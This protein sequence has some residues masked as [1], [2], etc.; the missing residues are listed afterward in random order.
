M[1]TRHRS[2]E[3]PMPTPRPCAATSTGG[4]GLARTLLAAACVAALAAP[5]PA[6]AAERALRGEAAFKA[7]AEAAIERLPAASPFTASDLRSGRLSFEIVYDEAAPDADPDVYTGRYPTAI[8]AFRVRIG[9]TAVE[10]PVTGAELR[11]SDG[12]FGLAHRESLQ[13]LAAARHGDHDLRVGWV[14]LNQRAPTEDLR[15][16]PGG[17]AGDAIPDARTVLAFPTSGEFDRVFFVRLDPV[18]DPRRPSLYL[19]TSTVTVAPAA[20]AS[21]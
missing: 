14:Q 11:V 2:K 10:L 19:S 5:G 4:A 21:R 17:I 12:G 3:A 18:A 9:A 1:N 13:L 20:V 8:R 15:G 16:A 6:R 7:P